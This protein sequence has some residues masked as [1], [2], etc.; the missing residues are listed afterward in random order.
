MNHD[1]PAVDIKEKDLNQN[2]QALEELLSK[3]SDESISSIL[4]IRY[5]L[6]GWAEKAL[7]TFPG[8]KLIGYEQDANT[9]ARAVKPKGATVRVK[10]FEPTKGM[11]A[12]ILL[13]DFNTTTCLKRETLDHALR[14]VDCDYLVFTDVCCS[15]LHLNYASYGLAEADL[16]KYWKRFKVD[17][18]KLIGFARVHHAAS[19]ALYIKKAPTG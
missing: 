10:R 3:I 16:K 18:Y 7:E 14:Y 19:S 15:K 11:K 1:T 6:G 9:A 17:G 13:A 12:D 8:A 5:G 2:T 4:D